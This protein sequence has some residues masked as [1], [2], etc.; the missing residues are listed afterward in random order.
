MLRPWRNKFPDVEVKEQAV[1]GRAAR[2]LLE[3][4]ADASLVVAGRRNRRAPL[5]FHTGPVTHAVM[6]HSTAPVAVVPHD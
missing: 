3:A 5:G 6:H 1:V 4:A 2:H